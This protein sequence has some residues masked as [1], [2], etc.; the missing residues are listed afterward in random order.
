MQSIIRHVYVIVCMIVPCVVLY[1]V[2]C[3]CVGSYDVVVD[4]GGG[5]YH[6]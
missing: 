6:M 3:Y 1:R 2:V 5:G 4:G